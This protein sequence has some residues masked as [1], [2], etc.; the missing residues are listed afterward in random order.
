MSDKMEKAVEKLVKEIDVNI[1]KR[2]LRFFSAARTPKD[3]MYLPDPED[4]VH[5]R[6]ERPPV[7]NKRKPIMSEAEACKV[8]TYRHQISPIFGFIRFRDLLF[9]DWII[10]SIR[11]LICLFFGYGRYGRWQTLYDM[12]VDG[13]AETIEGEHAALLH[14]YK[15][16]FLPGDSNTYL[17]DVSDISTPKF[18][19]RDSAAT[20]LTE[21]LMCGGHSFLSDGKLLVAAG[22]SPN[23]R[24]WKFDPVTETWDQ[25][26][27]DMAI[28]RWYPTLVTLG[29]ESGPTGQSGRV[30]VTSGVHNYDPQSNIAPPP[31][32]VYSE[33][34][35]TF[36]PVAVSGQGKKFFQTY[37]GLHLLP[38]GN[39]FYAA[40]GFGT[41][42]T[43]V[44]YPL[45]EPASIFNFS[46][47]NA[48]AWSDL[49]ANMNRT[50]GMSVLVFN[51]TYPF[52]RAFVFGGGDV[53]SQ[54]TVRGVN[55]SAT[56]P[57]WD[58]KH[59]FPDGRG[60]VNPNVVL[61]PDNTIFVNGGLQGTEGGTA[62]AQ[63]CWIFDPAKLHNPWREMDE[64]ETPRHYHSVSILLPNGQVMV[65]GGSVDGGCGMSSRNNVEVFSPPYLF[66]ADCTLATRP[67]IRKVNGLEPTP[68][69]SPT[70]H[71]GSPFTVDTPDAGDINR[72][73]LV[74]PMAVT[75]QTDT[76]QRVIPSCI[77][78]QTGAKEVTAVAPNW[79]H[80]HA[81]APRGY[82][83]L[84]IF[85]NRGTP[86]E[87]KF[88]HLH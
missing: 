49:G 75:H 80:P 22:K 87:G 2:I 36:E 45:D 53:Q 88:V 42:D 39:I 83:M 67:R 72:V 41:C 85:N 57:N 8:I 4:F 3:L 43:G 10:R 78:S 19:R 34:S 47:T 21:S 1:Q 32:E 38:N 77:V 71:H 23:P 84:F 25:T 44:V 63:N 13:E 70:I 9:D 60:R 64:L 15:V 27:D 12:K 79:S 31:V 20:G 51:P 26:A 68:D 66:N 24:A 46:G 33:A 69:V 28:S 30:L 82:Y 6:A 29:D 14:T 56:N 5:E 50:K 65:A 54:K 7:L 76:E 62:I 58:T 74:R 37:P 16:L 40:N 11:E 48:G 59:T 55:L 18:T 73:V 86:S 81:M 17:W 52:V 35:D 61:L